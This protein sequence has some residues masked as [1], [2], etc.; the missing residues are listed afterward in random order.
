M[1]FFKKPQKF[2]RTLW[3][4]LAMANFP[5]DIKGLS[6]NFLAQGKIGLPRP[7]FPWAAHV[8]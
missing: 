7:I 8:A 6:E 2:A 4:K 5:F 3:A 1:N